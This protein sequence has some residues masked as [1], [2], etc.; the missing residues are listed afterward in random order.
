MLVLKLEKAPKLLVVSKYLLKKMREHMTFTFIFGL[1][2][3]IV[4]YC[5]FIEK[6]ERKKNDKKRIK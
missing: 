6:R 4:S 2:I 1:N 5:V 3:S